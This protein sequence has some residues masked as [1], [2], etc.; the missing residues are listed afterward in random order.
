MKRGYKI[1][2]IG[3]CL[4]GFAQIVRL[5]AIILLFPYCG[6]GTRCSMIPVNPST[7][8]AVSLY[9][10]FALSDISLKVGIIVLIAGT[11]I[12]FWD[13]RKNSTNEPTI[14]KEKN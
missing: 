14:Y 6:Y 4:E 8:L 1:L 7:N 9:H 10:P 13:R 5:I 12:V 3:A 2:I 11:V